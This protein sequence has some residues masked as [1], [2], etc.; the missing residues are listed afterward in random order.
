[1]KISLLCV[2]S[3]CLVTGGLSRIGAEWSEPVLLEELNN[4]ESGS[5]AYRPSLS[6]DGLTIYFLRIED[7]MWKLWQAR[8]NCTSEAF[9]NVR[10]LSELSG[11]S[12][13]SES[14]DPSWLPDVKRGLGEVSELSWGKHLHNA[15][16]S[17]DGLR[18]YYSRHEDSHTKTVIRQAGRWEAAGPWTDVM[19][20]EDIHTDL[21][22][23]YLAS[24]TEDELTMFYTR[25][26]GN[27]YDRIYTATRASIDEQFSNRMEVV[28]LNYDGGTLGPCVMPDGLTIYFSD[29]RDGRETNDIYV[30]RRAA[31]DEPFG[32]IELVGVSTD[33]FTEQWVHVMPDE[34]TL[35]YYSNRGDAGAGIWVSHR[36][37]AV[38]VDIKPGACPNGL[39]LASRGVL[40][41]AV[42]GREDFDVAAIDAASI[43]LAG[44]AAVRSGY[45]DV[46]SASNEANE[47]ECAVTGA[48]G[49]TD[50]TLKFHTE[51]IAAGLLRSSGVL[52]KGGQYELELTGT[53]FD[54][55][56]IGGAGCVTLVGN[57][58]K[59][60]G[61]SLSDINGDGVVNIL[62]LSIITQYWLEEWQ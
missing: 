14:T 39:N 36:V 2:V 56:A 25:R 1:M 28:E 24:L 32:D 26:T 62:D 44:V 38:E 52:L 19:A 13:L 43:R 58:P 12:G 15:W 22:Y 27:R 4:S 21:S 10:E 35:Y 18:L 3:L 40:P 57:V 11:V 59:W 48:D 54:G 8:R 31:R 9:G 17:A 16:V 49:W 46:A 60:V 29:M 37:G 6:R 20:F 50:L 55:T 30:A 45:E 34:N 5:I 7:D 23:D 61:A 47:C 33:H 51:A 42:L 41:V 53:L